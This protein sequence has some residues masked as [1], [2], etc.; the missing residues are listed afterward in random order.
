MLVLRIGGHPQ[1]PPDL[2]VVIVERTLYN[3]GRH[4]S[5]A[6]A[7]RRNVIAVVESVV[8]DANFHSNDPRM[9][10]VALGHAA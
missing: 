8:T 3:T 5:A 4:A 1:L 7:L 9:H 6:E 2:L 10:G